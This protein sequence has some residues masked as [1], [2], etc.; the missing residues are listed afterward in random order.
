MTMKFAICQTKI[1]LKLSRRVAWG[2]GRLRD[3]RLQG[4]CVSW[5]RSKSRAIGE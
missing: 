1:S 3:E 2:I 5:Q 4:V